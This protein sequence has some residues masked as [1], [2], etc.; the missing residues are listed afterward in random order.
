MEIIDG[1]WVVCV[2]Y[3]SKWGAYPS[4]D[5]KIRALADD[6]APDTYW[7]YAKDE[8]INIDDIFNLIEETI[9]TNLDAIKKADLFKQK[10]EEL[11]SVFSDETNSTS[12]LETL[13]FVFQEETNDV[14][15]NIIEKKRKA[16]KPSVPKQVLTEPK[17]EKKKP[18]KEKIQEIEPIP[19]PVKTNIMENSSPNAE[20]LEASGL[21][22]AE[23]DELRG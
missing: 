14:M 11:K 18:V 20:I 6:N 5:G 17:E 15:S 7:Y 10:V 22:Q 2:R 3:S 23:I 16:K 12:K 19:E 13:R 21:S 8:N 4:D 9:Q 1:K